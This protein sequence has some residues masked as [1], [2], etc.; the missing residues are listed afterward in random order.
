MNSKY[1]SLAEYLSNLFGNQF[2]IKYFNNE[3]PDW[4]KVVI[5]PDMVYGSIKVLSG[6]NQSLKDISTYIEDCGLTIMIKEDAYSN[7]ID[8]IIDSIKTIDKQTILLAESY[9]QFNYSNRSDLGKYTVKGDFYYGCTLYFNLVSFE[10]LFLGE[11]QSVSISMSSGLV[12]LLGATGITYQAHTDFDSSVSSTMAN[13]NYI[14]AKSQVLVIDGVVVKDDT[15]RIAIK[16]YLMSNTSYSVSYFDGET[17]ISFVAKLADYTCLGISG[18]LV[19]Y[20]I[21]FIQK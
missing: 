16:K 11:Q 12:P 9:Y 8:S 18:N 21:K 1:D 14:A 6:Q 3:E 13:N 19:K 7:T 5:D 10:N 2:Y 4:E 20:Q 15:A 17:T